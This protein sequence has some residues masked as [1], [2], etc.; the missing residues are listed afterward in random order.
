MPVVVS[1]NEKVNIIIEFHTDIRG[2]TKANKSRTDV[3]GKERLQGYFQSKFNINEGRINY[4][5]FGEDKPVI[6]EKE[7]VKIK[8]L[9]E[10]ENAYA[11][12][13]RTVIIIT[14]A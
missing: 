12:N 2:D 6:S 7:I 1:L 4:A 9:K 11:K 14:K 10:R 3:C 8:D 5:S 13:R